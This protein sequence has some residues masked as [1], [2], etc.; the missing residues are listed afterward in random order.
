[1]VVA[2]RGNW[3]TLCASIKSAVPLGDLLTVAFSA[4]RQ[5]TD[6]IDGPAACDG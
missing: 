3:R 6:D 4:V 1:M 2:V 5:A